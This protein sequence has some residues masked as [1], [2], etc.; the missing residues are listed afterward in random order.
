MSGPIAGLTARLLSSRR[1][2]EGARCDLFSKTIRRSRV[3]TSWLTM[4]PS[5]VRWCSIDVSVWFNAVI[6]GDN[7]LITIGEGSNVQD[8][9]VI[10]TDPGDQVV[11][12]KVS[13]SAIG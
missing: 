10:H 7:D 11:L 5:L 6:R 1:R 4:R 9:A 8:G 12:E 3:T 2:P 13:P